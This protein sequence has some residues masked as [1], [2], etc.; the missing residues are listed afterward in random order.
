MSDEQRPSNPDEIVMDKAPEPA[1]EVVEANTP[2][3]AE[4][5]PV[6]VDPAEVEALRKYKEHAGYLMRETDSTLTSQKR[7]ALTFIMEQEGFG[8]DDIYRYLDAMEAQNNAPQM[9]PT[10]AEEFEMED[11]GTTF[12]NGEVRGNESARDSEMEALRAEVEMLRRQQRQDSTQVLRGRL[13]S[14]ME[15]EVERGVG[16]LLQTVERLNPEGKDAF[17][18]SI[19]ADLEKEI[20]DRLHRRREAAGS[21]DIN[22][23]DEEASRATESLVK[24][25]RAVIGDP[26]RV[27]RVPETDA[28]SDGLKRVEKPVAPKF[29]SSK[30]DMASVSHKARSFTEQA[31]RSL[32]DD[33]AKGG[34]TLM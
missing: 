9:E 14:A 26:D 23:V 12:P 34:K 2:P 18:E 32:A 19:K 24:K 16:G 13:N 22:W 4:E 31:L 3:P 6:T 11:N 33:A 8:K 15:R 5:A 21:F 17:S 28:G 10:A 25:Y 27:A 7:E 1:R 20:I 29:D 30:D